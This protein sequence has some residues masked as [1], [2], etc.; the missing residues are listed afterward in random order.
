MPSHG[1][2]QTRWNGRARRYPAQSVAT[3]TDAMAESGERVDSPVIVSAVNWS[4]A[5]HMNDQMGLLPPRRG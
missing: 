1:R 3:V 4:A 5:P 2:T